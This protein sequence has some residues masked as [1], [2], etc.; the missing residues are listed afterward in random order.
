MDRQSSKSSSVGAVALLL[1]ASK[2]F[3]LLPMVQMLL[4][5]MCFLPEELEIIK[6]SGAKEE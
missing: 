1:K 2:I 6:N 3:P 4:H 5:K